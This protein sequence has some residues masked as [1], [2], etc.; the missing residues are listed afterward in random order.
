MIPSLAAPLPALMA[1]AQNGASGGF[2][3][4]LLQIVAIGAVFYFLIIR[5]Q[6]QA[7]KRHE[8]LLAELKKG[9]EVT[10][11]GGIIGTVRN[12][13]DDRVTIDSGTATIVV[14][15][16]RIVRVGQSAVQE[17]RK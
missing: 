2:S 9:D 16:A 7:R 11:S 6:G 8:A 14:E 5:P 13:K 1:P 17:P 10:T 15:R 4:L 3:I 12:L